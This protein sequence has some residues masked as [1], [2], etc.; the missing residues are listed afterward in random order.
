MLLD[1]QFAYCLST[2]L[3]GE[4]YQ[5]VMEAKVTEDVLS[6]SRKLQ[7]H[8][9]GG[10]DIEKVTSSRILRPIQRRSSSFSKRVRR[11]YNHTCAVCGQRWQDESGYFEVEAAHIYP[12]S[13]VDDDDSLD[14]GPDAVQ[15]GLA[16]CRTHHWAFDHGWFTIEDDYVI[17]VRDDQSL[18]GY[19]AIAPYG[20]ERLHLPADPSEW[21]ARHYLAFHRDKVWTG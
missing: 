2:D 16:L 18:D 1:G 5:E 3:T 6:R 12:V 13:G 17:R 15:N 14:G 21:P 10:S 8:L 4:E 19:E 7:N 11:A 20:G 9:H